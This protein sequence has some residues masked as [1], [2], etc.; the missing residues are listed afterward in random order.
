[1]HGRILL[2]DDDPDILFA[3]Q[4]I[5]EEEGFEVDCA[6]DGRDALVCLA[7][8]ALPAA[9][10]LDLMM[11]NM[12]GWEFLAAARQDPELASIPIAVLSAA[13]E[14]AFPADVD[15][16]LRLRKPVDVSALITTLQTLCRRAPR[17]PPCAARWPGRR[18]VA[19][20]G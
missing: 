17:H 5:L 6:R 16:P 19:A 8:S 10:V 2:I 7:C 13:D 15:V 3:L 1:M 18:P 14:E 20:L 9:I 11:P 12:N 4:A